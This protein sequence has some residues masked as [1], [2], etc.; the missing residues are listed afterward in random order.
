AA[1]AEGLLARAAAFNPE[2]VFVERMAPAGGVDLIVGAHRDAS[3]GPLV[4]VGAGGLHA[5]ALDDVALALAPAD[6]SHVEALLRRLHVA[7]LL[8]GGRGRPPVD[9]DAVARV[10]VA[11]GDLLCGRP[12]LAEA[13]VN[14]LRAGADGALALDARVVVNPGD[15]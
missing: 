1:A 12:D 2:G 4:L 14:P 13:E 10:A 9:L 8:L 3:F 7:P 5:Q 11:L 6:A 15:A